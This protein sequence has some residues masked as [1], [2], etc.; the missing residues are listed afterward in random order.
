M[1]TTDGSWHAAGRV[2]HWRFGWADS[3]DRPAASRLARAWVGELVREHGLF[4]WTGIEPARSGVKPRFAGDPDADFSMSYS[5]RAVMVAVGTGSG[6]GV[7]VEAAPFRALHS[8]ALLRRMCSAREADLARVMAPDDRAGHLAQLWTAKEAAVKASGSGLAH[9]FRTFEF[10]L[11]PHTPATV[12]HRAPRTDSRLR[13]RRLAHRDS[14]R[15]RPDTRHR[16]RILAARRSHRTSPL[17]NPMTTVRSSPV[18]VA[19]A[20]PRSRTPHAEFMQIW[21][22]GYVSNHISFENMQVPGLFIVEGG[23][24]LRE[25]GTLDRAKIRAYVEA[26]MASGAAFR[27]RLQRSFLGLTPPAWVPDEDFDLDRHIIFADEI[28]D[29]SHVRSAAAVRL[30]RPGLLAAPSAVAPPGDGAHRRHRRDRH[31]DASRQPRRA[32]RDAAVLH[33]QPGLRG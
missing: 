21:E 4:S 1:T 15:P 11:P 19:A 3:A 31:D 13:R 28:A 23:P 22:E 14:G 32:L 8:D 5:G 33:G 27:L 20:E 10:D 6:V 7:D 29:L 9:D 25:D 16:A 17:R 24:L 18:A 2:V 30:G 12:G 26:T